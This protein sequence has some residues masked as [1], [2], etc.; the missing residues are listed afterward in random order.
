[1]SLP[2]DIDDGQLYGLTSQQCFVLGVEWCS[3]RESLRGGPL[4]GAPRVV[5]RANLERLLLLGVRLGHPLRVD[6]V[7]GEWAWVE[8][9][10]VV[11]GD[12]FQ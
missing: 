11:R 1:L 10:P 4:V 6:R 5:H 3:I 7:D 2:F 12:E 9:A 8:A